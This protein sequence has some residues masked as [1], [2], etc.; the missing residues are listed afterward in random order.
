MA[1]AEDGSGCGDSGPLG[2]CRGSSCCRHSPQQPP[3]LVRKN[4]Y[5]NSGCLGPRLSVATCKLHDHVVL[6]T[7]ILK[8]LYLY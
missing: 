8:Q 5:L 2:H 6:I 7:L 1:G 4:T 3:G